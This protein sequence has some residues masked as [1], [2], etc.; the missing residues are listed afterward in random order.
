MTPIRVHCTPAVQKAARKSRHRVDEA[1]AAVCRVLA[2]NPTFGVVVKGHAPLRKMRVAAPGLTT[3]KSGGY[4]LIYATA[5]V[6]ESQHCA[7][8][9][10]Y[11][12]GD[13]DDL[14]ASDYV[15]LRADATRILGTQGA[16]NDPDPDEA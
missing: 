7:L 14:A 8:L 9:A 12:K 10:L 13:R 4:R 15:A 3:G 6:D 11:F 16:A 2:I 5:R 1:C